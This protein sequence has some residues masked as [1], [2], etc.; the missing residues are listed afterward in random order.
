MERAGENGEEGAGE[1]TGIDGRAK[2]AKARE[3]WKGHWR[4]GR[5]QEQGRK[6]ETEG[7]RSEEERD[8]WGYHACTQLGFVSN[9][10][11][12]ICHVC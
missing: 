1:R 10:P 12:L 11:M 7:V 9:G 4:D 8:G 3:R 2:R 6:G 5:T